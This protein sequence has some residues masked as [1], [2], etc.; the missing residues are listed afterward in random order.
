MKSDPHAD[1]LD[2]AAVAGVQDD[3]LK[4]RAGR[5]TQLALLVLVPVVILV[6]ASVTSLAVVRIVGDWRLG[7]DPFASETVRTRLS[8]Y[9]L[10]ARGVVNDVLRQ[11]LIIA[12][13]LGL[14]RVIDGAAWRRRLALTR[15][16][17]P[18]APIPRIWVLW[19]FFLIWPAIHIAW[20]TASAEALHIT[21]GHGVRLS[22][23]LT[24]T[25]VVTWVVY[26]AVLAPV[27]EELLI[28][29][30]AFAR[31]S[32]FM[33]PAGAIVATAL[34][35]CLLHI[36]EMGFARPV[37]LLPLAITLGWLRWRTGRLW[38]GILLHGWSNLALVA[39]VLW[40]AVR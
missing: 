27:A 34:L 7:L 5:L 17:E 32:A 35:F 24:R 16:A 11:A 38:P 23:F 40:P 20:V 22:P 6:V 14:A 18:R 13:V 26:V 33:G 2:A 36:S 25:L 4:A 21:F 31:A 19:L 37:T 9:E 28:R 30:E 10:A 29:G 1:L 3:R 12:M 15:P 39:Y 8:L